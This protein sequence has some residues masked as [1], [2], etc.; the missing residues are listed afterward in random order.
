MEPINFNHQKTIISNNEPIYKNSE[1]M[2][3]FRKNFSKT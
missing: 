3:E 2:K 1:K